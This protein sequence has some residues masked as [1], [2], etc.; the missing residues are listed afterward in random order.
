M[1]VL[2]ITDDFYPSRGGI[3]ECMLGLASHFGS[4]TTVFA[5]YYPG[6]NA[7]FDK[8]FNFSVVRTDGL[9]QDRIIDRLLF[10]FLRR[11]LAFFLR[12]LSEIFHIVKHRK[13]SCILCGHITN[14]PTGVFL[15]RNSKIPLGVIVHG[16]EL[17]FRGILKPLKRS[18]AKVLLNQTDFLFMSNSFM[19]ETLI[20]MGIS[21]ERIVMIPF[22]V[23]WDNKLKVSEEKIKRDKKIILSVGRLIERKG[24]SAVIESLSLVLKRFPDIKYQIVGEGPME[25]R[26][27]VLVKEKN[28]GKN[29]EFCGE[30]EDLVPFYRSCDVFVMPSKFIED[31]GDV[32]GFG[33][34]FL[35]AN[36]FGKPVIAGRSGGISDAV[37]DGV[38]GFLVDPENPEKIA[39]AII[40]LFENPDLAK[41]M[42]E[43]GRRRVME[44]FTWERAAG[45]IEESLA[46][47]S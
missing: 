3:Q 9:R 6:Y 17:F 42:G 1:K 44:E 46:A 20:E 45:I 37:I 32:E 11:P 24:H 2:L 10:L 33:L 19:K 29:V 34:V 14:I 35:E 21:E 30:V 27:K 18:A 15:K 26:L 41:K 4:D 23:R 31:K 12:T 7:S 38:T 39:E 36:F 40:K 47:I 5:P 25:K 43:Q 22:G 28:L 13:F 8:R 16:K